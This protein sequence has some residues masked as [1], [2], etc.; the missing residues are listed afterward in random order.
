[1]KF[2][3]DIIQNPTRETTAQAKRC[4]IY[5]VDLDYNYGSELRNGHS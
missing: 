2:N 3:L 5:F 4:H 1:M